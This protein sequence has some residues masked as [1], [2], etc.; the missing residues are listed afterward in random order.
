MEN[1]LPVIYLVVL[2]VLLSGAGFSVIRQ[3][4]KTRSWKKS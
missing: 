1:S 4:L 2:L 3:V